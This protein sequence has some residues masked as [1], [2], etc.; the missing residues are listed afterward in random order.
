MYFLLFKKYGIECILL[1]VFNVT[2]SET[3]DF[4]IDNR[5]FFKLN[6]TLKKFKDFL[7]DFLN[8]YLNLR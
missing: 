8:H 6:S 7:F 1:K 2:S 3:F 5:F 4:F